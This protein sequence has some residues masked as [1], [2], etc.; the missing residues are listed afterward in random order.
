MSGIKEK[1]YKEQQAYW[2]GF[3]QGIIHIADVIRVRLDTEL[4][5]KSKSKSVCLMY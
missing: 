4:K 3:N 2:Y 1:D 5:N